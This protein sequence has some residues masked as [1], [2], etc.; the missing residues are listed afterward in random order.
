MKEPAVSVL[1][2][3]ALPGPYVRFQDPPS[4]QFETDL[5]RASLGNGQLALRLKTPITSETDAVAAV[6]PLLQAWEIRSGLRAGRPEIQ[7]EFQRAEYID[8]DPDGPGP[9][10]KIAVSRTLAVAVDSVLERVSTEY[11]EPPLDFAVD[12]DV[13]ALWQRYQDYKSRNEPL[14]AMAYFC[15]TVFVALGGG[16][17]RAAAKS[18]QVDQSVLRQLSELTS[19]RGTKLTARKVDSQF[20]GRPLTMREEEWVDAAVRL[21][22]RRLG[23]ARAGQFL[24]PLKM[25]DLPNL[26]LVVER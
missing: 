26:G 1:I 9:H 15:H 20:T 18:F 25:P 11:P 4:L 16:N 22:I 10:K 5:V 3:K 12:P 23:E 7:F 6:A 14:L 8:L 13:E 24:R 19:I 2:F 21:M 17:K